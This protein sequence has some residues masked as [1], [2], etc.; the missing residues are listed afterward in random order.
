MDENPRIL[1]L[2]DLIRAEHEA[3]IADE[4]RW[5]DEAEADGDLPRMRRHREV[6]VRLRAMPYPWELLASPGRS[7]RGEI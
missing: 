4:R 6:A 7:V 2:R 1:A 3:W 5:A